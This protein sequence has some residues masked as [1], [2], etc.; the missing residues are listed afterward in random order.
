MPA[1]Q[2]LWAAYWSTLQAEVSEAQ[3]QGL[4]NILKG[5]L[6]PSDKKRE[7]SK[8][9]PDVAFSSLRSFL[10]R[11]GSPHVLPSEAAFKRRFSQRAELRSIV[12]DIDE[13]ENRI[14]AAMEPRAKLEELIRRMY[15]GGKSVSFGE[16]EIEVHVSKEGT[17]SLGQLSSGEKQ[18][19]RLLVESLRASKS[20]LL[21]D[22]PE[23]SMHVDWQREL[24]TSMRSLNP[25]CQII[26]ATHS[27]EIMAD[28]DDSLISR[29]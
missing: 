25:Q 21:I 6:L 24:I 13:V 16:K 11:Q 4:A 15:S 8:L 14:S 18:V 12:S 23:L 5:V 17:I 27:P 7:N 26:I 1:G 20:S 19:L 10:K 9:D 22:E 3:S 2:S 28:V 29:L